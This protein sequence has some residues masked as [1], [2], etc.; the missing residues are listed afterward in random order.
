MVYQSSVF[1]LGELRLHE[2]PGN[3]IGIVT[4]NHVD[5]LIVAVL[6]ATVTVH[7]FNAEEGQHV[8]EAAILA[9]VVE[10]VEGRKCFLIFVGEQNAGRGFSGR[11][12]T[13]PGAFNLEFPVG[14]FRNSQP[15]HLQQTTNPNDS[16]CVIGSPVLGFESTSGGVGAHRPP[17]QKNDDGGGRVRGSATGR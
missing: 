13:C 9:V 8:L 16:Y 12:F 7:V 15:L 17:P 10:T 14:N 2:Q 3:F 11:M 4:G 5:R 1:I 6:L